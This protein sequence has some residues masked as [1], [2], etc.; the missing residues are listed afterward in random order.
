MKNDVDD[1]IDKHLLF[2]KFKNIEVFMSKKVDV[3]LF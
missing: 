1:K 3:L 2:F